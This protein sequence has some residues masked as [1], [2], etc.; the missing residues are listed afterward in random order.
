MGLYS[1][2]SLGPEWAWLPHMNVCYL[3]HF[4]VVCVAMTTVSGSLKTGLQTLAARCVL[5]ER[6]FAVV[7]VPR[8]TFNS[9]NNS[10][11]W[12][13]FR[14]NSSAGAPTQASARTPQWAPR[15]GR[16][17]RIHSKCTPNPASHKSPVGCRLPFRCRVFI[18][19]WCIYLLPLIF[20]LKAEEGGEM[21]GR[22]SLS[23]AG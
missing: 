8:N 22:G 12:P 7:Q 19:H 5:V 18:L 10:V 6:S 21:S 11:L 16:I 17:S 3:A 9:R 20:T 4:T 23:T 15:L 13:F 1:A 14:P 2:I